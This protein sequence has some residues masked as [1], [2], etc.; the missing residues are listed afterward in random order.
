M[1][2][3]TPRSGSEIKAWRRER[4]DS[5]HSRVP[6]FDPP[7]TTIN[8]APGPV[9]SHTL[10][11][12]IRRRSPGFL[13]TTMTLTVGAAD[14]A[15]GRSIAHGPRVSMS[16]LPLLSIIIVAY[17]SRD[18]FAAGLDSLPREL[19][20]VEDRCAAVEVT[21]VDNSPGDG[22]G[23]FA[24]RDFPGVQCVRADANHVFGRA[25]N[26][27][28]ARSRGKCVLFLNPDT[29]SN[30]AA[31]AQCVTRVRDAATID[32]VGAINVAFMLTSRWV[33]EQVA[34]EGEV[35]DARFFMC[36]DDPDLCIRESRAG[37]R[38]ADDGR[39]RITHL[40]G[41]SA[42]REFYRMAHGI[43][44]ANWDVCL[45]HFNPRGSALVRWKYAL[46]FGSWKRVA[47]FKAWPQGHRQVRPL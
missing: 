19:P 25:N 45:K 9:C 34:P 14:I 1:A 28:C 38:I 29:V 46:T 15:F 39:D 24:R 11:S 20:G 23:D 21:V 18:E 13:Q 22:T 32:E 12:A 44:D 8:P 2:S 7:S 30:A 3:Y 33:L 27:G 40:T 4:S 41:V 5:S 35:F 17:R 42:A 16:E 37:F 31:L 47:P 10:L 36:G 43:F 6:S 26:L